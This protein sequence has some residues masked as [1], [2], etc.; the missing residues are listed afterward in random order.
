VRDA[1]SDSPL[2]SL[3]TGPSTHSRSSL[4]WFLGWRYQ[5]LHGKMLTG[6]ERVTS[7]SRYMYKRP[8]PACW[9]TSSK[10]RNNYKCRQLA[11]II[12]NSHG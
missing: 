8:K 6:F 3:T 11:I 1:N 12:Q 7:Q 5:V 4:R 2:M 9:R 10:A